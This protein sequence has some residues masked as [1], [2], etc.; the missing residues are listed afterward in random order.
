[1]ESRLLGLP[2]FLV[3]GFCSLAQDGLESQAACVSFPSLVFQVLRLQIHV[4]QKV[5]RHTCVY[6]PA[7]VCGGQR[8]T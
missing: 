3:T 5:C 4:P 2:G 1:M 7:Q 8:T 6:V